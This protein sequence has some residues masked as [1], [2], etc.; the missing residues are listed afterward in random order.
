MGKIFERYGIRV[1]IFILF[2]ALI[3]LPYLIT[4]MVTY[5]MFLDYISDNWGKSMEDTMISIENQVSSMLEVYEKSTMNLY[6]SGCVEMLEQD[7]VDREML[8]SILNTCCYS[9]RG[10][11]SV[12]LVSKD[13]VYS[14]GSWYGNFVKIMEPYE[15]EIYASSGNCLWYTT[16]E[17]YGSVDSKSYIL[18]RGLNGEEKDNLG[19]LYYIVG[20]RMIRNAFAKLQ[21]DDCLKYIVD[22]EGNVLYSSNEEGEKVRLVQDLPE[23]QEES[24]YFILKDGK[25]QEVLAYDTMAEVGWTFLSYI[26][27][28]NLMKTLFPVKTV[29]LIISLFYVLF[30]VLIFYLFQN[31]FIKPVTELKYAMDRFAGGDMNVHMEE[32]KS[33]EL[34]S[35]SE[36]F[37]SMTDEINELIRHNQEV[38][39]EKN[40]FKMQVLMAK[41][42]PHFIF[43]A[44]NTIKWMSVISQQENIQKVSEALIYILMNN[45]K[46]D[47]VNYD[48]ADEIE[49][50]KQYAVIQKARFM[51]F[52]IQVEM[53]EDTLHCRIFQF[54]LQPVVENSIVHGFQRGMSRGGKILIKS[55]I[56]DDLLHIIVKDNGCGFD[57]DQWKNKDEPQENHTNVGLRYIKQIIQLECGTDYGLEIESC[58]GEGT[59]VTYRLPAKRRGEWHD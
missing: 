41:L 22:K 40:N 25:R 5:W 58:P 24:G 23:F 18:A 21:M 56:K 27:L 34:K 17:L 26:S 36:H 6:Y 4:I 43:N 32:I 47:N 50:I 42:H 29:F 45:T 20:E 49:L 31:H 46:D 35:L 15:Q 52:E 39:N 14:S 13:E 2:L 57:V 37:N 16:D 30:L 1:K 3:M 9:N 53:E 54:L 48:L 51:N 44:L 10:V 19:I 7:K 33:V 28:D 8:E 38:V 11:K 55:W 12:Y 59:T